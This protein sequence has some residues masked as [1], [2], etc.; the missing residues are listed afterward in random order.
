MTSEAT[1]Q[2]S[3]S[4]KA[5]WFGTIVGIVLMAVIVLASGFKFRAVLKPAPRCVPA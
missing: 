1:P 2:K 4:K 3:G 5:W